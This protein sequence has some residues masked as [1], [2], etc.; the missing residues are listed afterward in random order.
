MSVVSRCWFS[1]SKT[2]LWLANAGPSRC[3]AIYSPSNSLYKNRKE[4]GKGCLNVKTEL[5][6]SSPQAHI[7]ST[8]KQGPLLSPK[9]SLLP[10]HPDLSRRIWNFFQSCEFMYTRNTH[11]RTKREQ[12]DTLLS[13]GKDLGHGR[14]V[15]SS[16][17]LYFWEPGVLSPKPIA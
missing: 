14:H 15:W 10:R 9:S 6:L 2:L 4:A 7:V 16:G 11:L 12:E 13:C 5:P 8:S 3:L 17:C 1:E